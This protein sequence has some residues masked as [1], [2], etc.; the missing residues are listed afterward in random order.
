MSHDYEKFLDSRQEI[1]PSESLNLKIKSQ[2][3]RFITPNLKVVFFKYFSLFSLMALISL[4][5]CP[6][7]GL[8]LVKS[9]E[10]L[11]FFDFLHSNPTLCG[12][13][14]GLFFFSSTH[15]VSFMYL[16][17]FE[18]LWLTKKLWYLPHTIYSFCFG[19]FMLLS[20]DHMNFKWSYNLS[21]AAVVFLGLS[22]FTYLQKSKAPLL[23]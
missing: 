6:Q 23:K 2:S 22:L 8:G 5:L 3:Q 9:S 7:K 12:L 20:N 18:R 14:C 11:F 4:A 19:F 1:Q 10:Y 13:Y 21:W 15:L 17:H 16:N